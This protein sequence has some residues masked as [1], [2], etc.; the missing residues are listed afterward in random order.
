MINQHIPNAVPATN[1][2]TAPINQLVPVTNGID[3]RSLPPCRAEQDL[4]TF[5]LKPYQRYC[6][7][8]IMDTPHIGL[9]LG[10]S[11]GKTLITLSGL[12][13]ARIQ[14]PAL[15]IAPAAVAKATWDKEIAKYHFPFKTAN[16]STV[17]TK[18]GS[19]KRVTPLQRHRLLKQAY[20]DG[21]AKRPTINIVS[22]SVLADIVEHL[23]RADTKQLAFD[24]N[25][26]IQPDDITV[27]QAESIDLDIN[28]DPDIISFDDLTQYTINQH[29]LVDDSNGPALTLGK[30]VEVTAL[31]HMARDKKKC[32]N[33][34]P[35]QIGHRFVYIW[36]TKQGRIHLANGQRRRN[37]PC[38]ELTTFTDA[39]S[40]GA[41]GKRLWPFETVVI[42][43]ASCFKA[44]NSGRFKAIKKVR[45][46]IKRLIE[47]T[48][49]PQP[50]SIEQ[51]W[52]L[53]WMLDM[54]KRLGPTITSFRRTFEYGIGT[55]PATGGPLTYI[56]L[57]GADTQIHNLISDIT[58]SISDPGL[59][60]D[61]N[62]IMDD[63][64]ID[65][66]ENT[67]DIYKM[68]MK[69]GAIKI[70]VL[71]K[72]KN[73]MLDDTGE[74]IYDTIYTANKAV[75]VAKL[76]QMASG[77][78]YTGEIDPDVL[79]SILGSTNQSIDDMPQT[80][81]GRMF[82]SIHDAKLDALMDIIRD[83]GSPVLVC[84]WFQ[85]DMQR[86]KERLAQ[87]HVDFEVFNGDPGQQ[88]RWNDGNI[89][90][91]LMHPASGAYGVNLQYGGHDI[92]WY[93]MPWSLEL[94]QQA[95][96][97]LN[98]LGQANPVIIHRIITKKTVDERIAKT[99]SQKD[100]AQRQLL[101]DITPGAFRQSD[102]TNAHTANTKEGTSS[103]Q[104][105]T[106][107]IDP[108]G[109]II[110]ELYS[111]IRQTIADDSTDVA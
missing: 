32:N 75:L 71:D 103:T 99:L 76:V 33:T 77:T 60:L 16:L 50:G 106:A 73:P 95:N 26:R 22:V 59:G 39:M 90:V 110:D 3:A 74:P 80:S 79:Q 19:T 25:I 15:V 89:P 5:T 7:R 12:Y 13:Q 47:L 8:R 6:V 98:R 85:T 92:V 72:H 10:M 88:D 100:A 30:L 94:Y 14:R 83:A 66:D 48:G 111:Y 57:D 9:Y 67:R 107:T 53:V 63:V 40:V 58:I 23:P 2:G 108:H 24:P 51:L 35:E 55:N 4:H 104:P 45:R 102:D 87:E 31:K 64:E 97:R 105:T 17:T 52:P 41:G 20:E 27:E 84:Y 28:I 86:I 101:D 21:K 18:R 38:D 42:D 11:S 46:A 44:Y 29:V 62:I 1:A 70:P 78:M 81:N 109:N 96:F 34:D 43:E 36:P 82:L 56:P 91:L 68:L 54:G 61:K 49:T 93:T 65:L 37:N 69:D